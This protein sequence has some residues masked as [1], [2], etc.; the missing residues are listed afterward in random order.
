MIRF[1]DPAQRVDRSLSL[2][3]CGL[4]GLT[5]CAESYSC[6]VEEARSECHPKSWRRRPGF[7]ECR[8]RTQSFH[9]CV[10]VELLLGKDTVLHWGAD[11]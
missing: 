3:Q 11:T 7:G 8:Q 2:L 9:G 4:S 6:E 10:A 5:R 1:H